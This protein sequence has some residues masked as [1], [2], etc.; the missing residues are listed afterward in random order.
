MV[1]KIVVQQN[2][3]DLLHRNRQCTAWPL[4]VASL[5]R[6][7]ASA[8]EGNSMLTC[9]LVAW[10]SVCIGFL[11]GVTWFGLCEAAGPYSRRERRKTARMVGV[12]RPN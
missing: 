12:R 6:S 9:I 2:F 8:A 3:C 4:E 7:P 10:G 1:D 5:L 11:L